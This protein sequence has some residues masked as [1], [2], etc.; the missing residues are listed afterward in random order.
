[1]ISYDFSKPS[2]Y[3]SGRFRSPWG[4]KWWSKMMVVSIW[5]LEEAGTSGKLYLSPGSDRRQPSD[6]SREISTC[7][8]C[9]ETWNTDALLPMHKCT[10][11][12]CIC[13]PT[14][15][16]TRTFTIQYNDQQSRHSLEVLSIHFVRGYCKCVCPAS[17]NLH[18]T[19]A[20]L[21]WLRTLSSP[22]AAA[23]RWLEGSCSSDP[24]K[25]SIMC[26]S[27][28]SVV[29]PYYYILWFF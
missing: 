25:R 29:L 10:T 26:Y 22:W 11:K 5:S 27:F 2:L 16:C 21:Q 13:V 3:C 28:C 20:V 7:R 15:F 1:M 23:E 19:A 6:W 12:T 4:G 14:E 18:R 24:W 8:L 9:M 17:G